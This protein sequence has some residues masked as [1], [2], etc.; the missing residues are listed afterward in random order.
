MT[1]EP[2]LLSLREVSRTFGSA[3][4]GGIR[5]A[6]FD[7]RRGEFVAIV[8]TS[9]AGKSTLLNILGLLDR[10]VS[11][12]YF[13]DGIDT[14]RLSERRRNRL[15]SHLF[16]FVFQSAFVLGHD[17]VIDNAALGLRIQGVP[18]RE[19]A[20]RAARALDLVG[21][22]HRADADARLLSGGERQRLAIA[23]AVATRP[24]LVL[25]DEP[26]GNL[27]SVNG[28]GVLQQLLALNAAGTTVVLITHDQEL[29]ARA[30][31]QMRITDGRIV[32]D[33][34]ALPDRT[35]IPPALVAPPPRPRRVAET[36][37]DDL[38]ESVTSM[39]S[40][41]IRTSLL[42]VA[43][44][45]GVGG[46]IAALGV[47]ESASAQVTERL[48]AAALDEVRVSL[49]G[50]A[51]LLTADSEQLDA[52][53]ASA[54]ALPH[55]VDVGYVAQAGTDA[56]DIRRLSVTDDEPVAPLQLISADPTY[57]R[58][59]G[60][61]PVGSDARGL[62]GSPHVT[63]IALLGSA[64]AE[65]LHTA[66]P[67]PGSS[68]WINNYRVSV[69]GT[70]TAGARMPGLDNTVIVSDDVIVGSPSVSVSLLVRTDPGYPAPLAEALPLA[71][72]PANPG[73]FAVETVAD[74]RALRFGVSSDLGSLIALISVV[75]LALAT[76]SAS[77]TM[78]LSVQSRAAEIALR[79][80][81][82]ASRVDVARL[83]LW[84]GLIIGVTGGITG[85]VLGTATTLVAAHAQGWTPLLPP[86]LTP[87]S[88]ALGALTGIISAIVPA[89]S[90]SRQEPA[91]AIKN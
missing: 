74:L 21:I 68:L 11:G 56:A 27:D 2:P 3:A 90:A 62:M 29:A 38:G 1:Q 17:S 72:D 70:V 41:L 9:G 46:L 18:L 25:A 54:R 80:A 40:R 34:G 75:L 79:R 7:I 23:R 65:A 15:R 33:S 49:P 66:A 57:L 55:V 67:G 30:H 14:S 28:E 85:A 12:T 53:I 58:L 47:S 87:L 88:I 32:S 31:R 37:A 60:A 86:S 76:I 16:G 8:G 43:F 20:A 35:G 84:E 36:V 82:G 69:V 51:T 44:A 64:A 81:I 63:G 6:S 91:N 48:T 42:T 83:F 73:R 19:R 45:L 22:S 61:K 24:A 5:D 39:A 26:T 50:G 10:P 71:M 78:Y 89:W 4:S 77:T 52:W 59:V 13:V